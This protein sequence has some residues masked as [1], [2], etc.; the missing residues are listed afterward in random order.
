MRIPCGFWFHFTKNTFRSPPFK[1]ET[2]QTGLGKFS[3]Q[4]ILQGEGAS[5]PNKTVSRQHVG[6]FFASGAESPGGQPIYIYSA[7]SQTVG[8]GAFYT[9]RGSETKI[10]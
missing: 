6:H 5:L 9:A 4:P 1:R 10:Y 3:P 2:T 7:I 8:E